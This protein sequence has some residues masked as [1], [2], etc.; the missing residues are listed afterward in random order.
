MRIEDSNNTGLVCIEKID[1]NEIR[2]S[3]SLMIS[4]FRS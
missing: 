3:I 1:A 4:Q 2:L